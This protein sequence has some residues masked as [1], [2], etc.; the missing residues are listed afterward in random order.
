LRLLRLLREICAVVLKRTNS[1]EAAKMQRKAKEEFQRSVFRHAPD[2]PLFRQF[3]LL[4]IL[5]AVSRQ[6]A[7][8]NLV[9]TLNK[10]TSRANSDF[11]DIYEFYDPYDFYDF[12][13]IARS[14]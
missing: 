11:Y 8:Y 7:T 14:P 3:A 9:S 2:G 5:S 12:Y 10:I 13:E 4:P 6:T 1:H